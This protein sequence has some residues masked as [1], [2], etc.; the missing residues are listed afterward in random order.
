MPRTELSGRAGTA[1]PLR[2]VAY[3]HPSRLRAALY[4][5]DAARF[6]KALAP[7]QRG[8]EARELLAGDLARSGEQPGGAE[9][10]LIVP[11]HACREPLRQVLRALRELRV[12]LRARGI[13]P[14]EPGETGREEARDQDEPGQTGEFTP[15]ELRRPGGHYMLCRDLGAAA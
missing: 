7:P 10:D 1:Q 3:T 4:P 8:G 11:A 13:P 9:Q 2:L 15:L 5:D 12:V 6:R 14:G